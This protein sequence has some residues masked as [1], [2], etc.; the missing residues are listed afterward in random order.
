[1]NMRGDDLERVII[2][3]GVKG[4]PGVERLNETGQRLVDQLGNRP[5][6]IGG[7]QAADQAEGWLAVRAHE[8]APTVI[9]RRLPWLAVG[10]H[11]KWATIG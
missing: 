4:S 8:D 10:Y 11:I 6:K 5:G 2:D 9:T 1:V 3:P 7:H